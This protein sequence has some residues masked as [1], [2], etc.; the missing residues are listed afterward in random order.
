MDIMKLNN[1]TKLKDNRTNCYSLIY[2]MTVK[3][4]LTLVEEIYKDKGGLKEQREPLKSSSA[5]RIR[6][7]M[8]KDI[9]AGTV[10]PPIVL[11]L[12]ITEKEFHLIPDKDNQQ[13]TSLIS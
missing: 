1:L 6:K 7:Q 9:K 5:M 4:Y 12:I 3:D 2:E 10:L 8:V 13:F 11:G